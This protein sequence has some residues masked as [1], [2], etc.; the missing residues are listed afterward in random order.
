MVTMAQSGQLPGTQSSSTTGGH[1]NM[2][3]SNAPPLWRSPPILSDQ[4]SIHELKCSLEFAHA[5]IDTLR[6]QARANANL[7]RQQASVINKLQEAYSD[8]VDYAADLEESILSLDTN[9]RKKNLII[10]GI[11]EVPNENPVT[12]ILRLYKFFSQYVDTLEREDFDTAYRLGDPINRRGKKQKQKQRS[13]PIVVKFFRESV[14]NQISQVRFDLDDDASKKKIYV[15]DD[16]PKAINDRRSLMRVVVKSAKEKN[17][18]AKLSGGKLTVNNVSY[19][20]KNLDCL[21]KGLRPSAPPTTASTSTAP[22]PTATQSKQDIIANQ[23]PT[24]PAR[25]KRNAKRGNEVLSPAKGPATS[26][27]KIDDVTSHASSFGSPLINRSPV[28]STIVPPVDL[29]ACPEL[30]V[31]SKSPQVSRSTQVYEDSQL[32]CEDLFACPTEAHFVS[33][34]STTGY[35]SEL[36]TTIFTSVLRKCVKVCALI[37]E[38]VFNMET[39]VFTDSRGVNLHTYLGE[40]SADNVR[41]FYFSGAR[42]TDIVLRSMEYILRYRPKLVIYLGGVNDTTSLNQFTRKLKPRF[43]NVM[44][45]CEHFT[46]VINSARLLLSNGFPD[47]VVTFGGVIGANLSRFNHVLIT[48]PAQDAYN[49]SILELN[50]VIRQLNIAAHAPHLY[51]TAKVHK[52]INGRCYHQYFHLYDGLHLNPTILRHWASLI[53]GLQ[54]QVLG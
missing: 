36:E 20:H 27:Q 41:V 7:V 35:T 42:L 15:N 30:Q 12:L 4:P 49:E 32:N 17:I 46:D 6:D 5:N 31:N 10:T 26:I 39:A 28:K 11:N 21:P 9:S 43:R 23:G 37:S 47:M 8:I 29:Y 34:R 22:Q 44:E 51:F 1:D 13:R 14:R 52:W 45:L 53:L 54:L 19:S 25:S 24:P 18:P 50:R 3:I 40:I 16:H 48:D 2:D 33:Q 38:L